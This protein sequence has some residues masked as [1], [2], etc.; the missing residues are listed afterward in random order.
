MTRVYEPYLKQHDLTYPQYIVMLVLFEDLEIEFT[1]L[2][3]R[4]DLRK[5]TLT[6]IL[7][8]LELI[9]YI[10]KIPSREDRRKVVISL[11]EKGIKLK[12]DIIN[13]PLNMYG[14]LDIDRE[15]Y[16]NLVK[17][18]DSLL[19]ILKKNLNEKEKDL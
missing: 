15:S 18:L 9:G 19:V 14:T 10:K 5:A 7:N 2:S 11:S 17:E 13:V 6:P 1:A 3:N 8:R 12:E 4:I 16:Y